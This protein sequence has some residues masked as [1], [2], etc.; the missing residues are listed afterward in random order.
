MYSVSSGKRRAPGNRVA[1]SKWE[2]LDQDPP[3]GYSGGQAAS[4]AGGHTNLGLESRSGTH[5]QESNR[6]IQ[7]VS[8]IR[9]V[10]GDAVQGGS[11]GGS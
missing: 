2:L 9:V 8:W 10:A 11:E 7:Q 1:G 3:S 6:S 5:F 4:I